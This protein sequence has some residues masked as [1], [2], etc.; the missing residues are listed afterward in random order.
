MRQLDEKK[1]E[2]VREYIVR[3]QKD[4][5]KSP[6]YRD[7]LKN[8]S[9]S[10]MG[11]VY[12]YVNAL[13]ERG[14]IEKD[15]IG[16]IELPI[17]LK[18]SAT[19]IAPIIGA[20]ACGSPIL[21]VEDIEGSLALPDLFGKG[22]KFVLRAKGDSMI[23]AGIYSGDLL[24]IERRNVIDEGEIVIAVIESTGEAEATAKRFYRE[25]GRKIRLK[26]EN[27]TMKDMIYNADEVNICGVVVGV[28]RS[29]I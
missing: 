24:I 4:K 11:V 10:G 16:K 23:N 20:V 5:G 28:I 27:D 19:V 13:I 12:R 29:Y 6:P 7:I 15:R 8:L 1:V 2:E 14:V 22:E 9:F 26:P 21:A 3:Y 17:N 18:P 25:R